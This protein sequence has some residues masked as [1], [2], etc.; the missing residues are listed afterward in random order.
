LGASENV[1]GAADGQEPTRLFRILLDRSANAGDMVV[2]ASVES[3]EG[4]AAKA[5]HDLIS[6][7]NSARALGQET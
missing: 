6:R 5:L 1:P 3:V 2:D 7:E 4:L